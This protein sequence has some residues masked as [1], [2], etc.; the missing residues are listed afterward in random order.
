M[1]VTVSQRFFATKYRITPFSGN[2]RRV[3]TDPY[4]VLQTKTWNKDK[5]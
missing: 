2:I 5:S 3:A 1:R 4:K